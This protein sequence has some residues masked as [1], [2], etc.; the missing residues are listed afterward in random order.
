MIFGIFGTLGTWDFVSSD[1]QKSGTIIVSALDFLGLC[2]LCGMS[3]Q[4]FCTARLVLGGAFIHISSPMC[5]KIF[6]Y[7]PT[8]PYIPLFI[9]YIPVYIPMYMYAHTH[10][11]IYIYICTYPGY[12]RFIWCI[13]AGLSSPA[14][15]F[16]S[17]SVAATSMVSWHPRTH[18][19]FNGLW[20]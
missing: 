9:P 4:H 15:P 5:P 1:F 3:V 11:H 10:P 16:V 13:A 7:V 14:S 19:F 17:S 12:D 18:V 6:L 2:G 20:V 8:Y